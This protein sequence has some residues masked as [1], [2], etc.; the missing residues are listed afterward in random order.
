MSLEPGYPALVAAAIAFVTVAGAGLLGD[1]AEAAAREPSARLWRPEAPGRLARARAARRLRLSQSGL[2]T[3]AQRLG[4]TASAVLCVLA[5]AFGGA[6]FAG[7]SGVAATVAWAAAG[8]M[9]GQFLV[10]SWL[11]DRRRKLL[12]LREGSLP[13]ALEL[14]C[15]GVNGGLSL[16]AAWRKAAA[17]L[18]AAREPL[19]EELRLVELDVGLGRTWRSALADAAARTGMTSLR[20]L[21]QL[22]EQA[23]RFGSELADAIRTGADSLQHEE[24]QGLEERAHRSSVKMLFPLAACMLPATVLLVLGPLVAMTLDALK[25]ASSD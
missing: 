13:L 12:A 3:P 17:G 16:G 23:E 2:R 8:A 22:L 19:A 7:T 5:F 24:M 14:L 10:R 6:L 18:A 25:A 9:Y 11:E 1:A 15:I 4:F 21:G 20:D